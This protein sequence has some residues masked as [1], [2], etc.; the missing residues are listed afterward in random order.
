MSG[1]KW[2]LEVINWNDI[3]AKKYNGDRFL[4]TKIEN[5][6]NLSEVW[7]FLGFKLK[8]QRNGYS[9]IKNGIEYILTRYYYI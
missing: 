5:F 8:K 4:N 7:E 2:H 3:E 9:G 1:L 6:F